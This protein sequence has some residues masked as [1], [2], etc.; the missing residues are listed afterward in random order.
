MEYFMQL[1]REKGRILYDM[2]CIEKYIESGECDQNLQKVWANYVKKLNDIEEK[3]GTV[4]TRELAELEDQKLQLL[5][6]K[7]E[8]EKKI[9]ELDSQM[10]DI[11]ELILEREQEGYYE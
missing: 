1:L 3:L 5:S 7:E 2:N 9:V 11:D 8:H 4:R 6:Q 10:K